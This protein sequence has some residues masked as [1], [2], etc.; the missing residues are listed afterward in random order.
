LQSPEIPEIR[1]SRVRVRVPLCPINSTR[2]LSV[3]LS[4]SSFSSEPSGAKVCPLHSSSSHSLSLSLSLSLSERMY[5]YAGETCTRGLAAHDNSLGAR[6]LHAFEVYGGGVSLSLLF[7]LSFFTFK[8]RRWSI[9]STFPAIISAVAPLSLSLSQLSVSF[10]VRLR[11]G[12]RIIQ[13]ARN[14]L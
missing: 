7:I 6:H 11:D 12:L 10:G 2:S 4:W 1:C 5:I 14:E 8:R 13:Y 9:Q 3:S